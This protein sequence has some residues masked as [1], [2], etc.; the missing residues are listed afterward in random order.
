MAEDDLEKQ[1][2]NSA[3]DSILQAANKL[4]EESGKVTQAIKSIREIVDFQGLDIDKLKRRVA[5]S[6]GDMQSSHEFRLVMIE[7]DIKNCPIKEIRKELD[8][9]KTEIRKEFNL[10]KNLL[11]AKRTEDLATAHAEA[12]TEEEKQA[13][14]A[15]EAQK[16]K[17]AWQL[18]WTLVKAMPIRSAI[19]FILITG[20]P[21]LL[22]RCGMEPKKAHSIVAPI[23]HEQKAIENGGE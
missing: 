4:A 21:T 7:R 15:A 18:I 12:R 2:G 17:E 9:H 11:L 19:I 6:N 5:G 20:L 8:E 14:Q 16:K 3:V 22:I 23:K 13:E 10:F 1:A